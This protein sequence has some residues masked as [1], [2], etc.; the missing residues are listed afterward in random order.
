MHCGPFIHTLHQGPPSNGIYLFLDFSGI[1]HFSFF[2]FFL[3]MPVRYLFIFIGRRADVEYLFIFI[4]RPAAGIFHFFILF[5]FP[6]HAC[7]VFIYFYW[8]PSRYRVF[9]YSL[10][11]AQPPVFFHF[12]FY[13]FFLTAQIRPFGPWLS[14]KAKM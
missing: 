8:P 12:S 10:L 4:G 14:F 9:I 2:H 6:D 3:I 5:I 7:S 1:F 13:S 11:A